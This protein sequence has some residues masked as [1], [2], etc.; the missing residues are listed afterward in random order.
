[1]IVYLLVFTTGLLFIINYAVANKDYMNPS[2]IFCAMNFLCASICVVICIMYAVDFHFNGY[3]V[4]TVGAMIFTVFNLIYCKGY[5]IHFQSFI[6][7]N[8]EIRSIR[9]THI[10]DIWLLFFL[11][12]EFVVAFYMAK[13]VS[14]ISAAFY[15]HSTDLLT[16]AANY[17]RILKNYGDEMRQ[18]DVHAHAFYTYGW[19]LVIATNLIFFSV[20]VY[21]FLYFKKKEV[22]IWL[23]C[24]IMV[25]MSFITGARSTAFKLVLALVVEFV[26]IYRTTKS[27]IGE[28]NKKIFGKLFLLGCIGVVLFFAATGW[29]GRRTDFVLFE[30][31]SAYIGAPLLNLDISLQ[32]SMY[33]TKIWGQETFHNFYS[34]IGSIFDISWLRY[35]LHQPYLYLNGHYLGNVYTMYYMFIEDFGYFGIVPLTSIV[36]WFY[37]SMYS[38]LKKMK[39]MFPF[40]LYIYSYMF[41]SIFT[42]VFT[43]RFYEDA[44][45][46]QAF[47][48][49]FWLMI[50][51]FCLRAGVFRNGRNIK[52]GKKKRCLCG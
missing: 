52:I 41:S 48:V 36:A 42:L 2:V 10:S 21:N 3:F 18:L 12:F 39:K 40:S 8:T 29:L 4:L 43:N 17:N 14:N 38:R 13:Y 11:F 35:D 22:L 27:S 26:L 51:L 9:Y 1:M 19:P 5:R 50:V 44:M 6:S 45:R 32:S 33:E 47:R 15:G 49:Y 20:S 7:N 24:V 23:A 46:A 31:V 16:S 37:S 34:Y 30:Y 28:G 25:L